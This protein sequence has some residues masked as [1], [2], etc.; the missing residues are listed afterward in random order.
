MP[1][2]LTVL[3]SGS[4]GNATLLQH[5]EARVLIDIGLSCRETARRLGAVGVAPESIT[6][7][8]ITHAHGDHTRGAALFS[9][10]YEV[11]VHATEAT[12]AVWPDA[13]VWSWGGLDCDVAADIGGFRITP[14][15]VSHD[16]DAETVAFHIET[17]AGAIGFA[18]DIGMTT[19]ALRTRFRPCRLLVMESNH[20]T[21]LLQVG[22]YST[23]TKARIA[24]ERG[25]LSNEA[26]ARFVRDDLGASVECLVLA[27]LSRVNNLPELA[28][29]TCREALDVAGRSDVRVVVSHQER[30]T[31]TVRL[32]VRPARSGPDLSPG[33]QIALP[34][35]VSA[36]S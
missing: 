22:P 7:A 26:L 17:P 32:D 23:S 30:V 6:A 3:G 15:E 31:E 12:R 24:G 25:H 10:R 1:V 9:R 33:R 4:A 19:R 18:T 36:T 28:A 21:D 35:Q 27:H 2:L 14:F 13:D 5:R 20:A 16:A 8:V 34:F 29:M 11:P